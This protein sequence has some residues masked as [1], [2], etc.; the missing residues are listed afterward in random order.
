MS[1][2]IVRWNPFRE[3]AAMREAMDRI[4]EETWRPFFEEVSQGAF[5]LAVDVHE[6]NNAYTVV[7]SLPGVA[8][9]NINVRL[10][11]DVLMID[12]EIP[13]RVVEK[14]GT[15][16]LLR[17]RQY[18][19]FSRRIRLPQPVDSSKVEAQ[20]ENGVLTLTLPKA[21]EAQPKVIP[22]KVGKS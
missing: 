7:T 9:E 1:D 5:R 6:D 22:V 11:G 21:A 18:G 15:Q 19:R 16:T 12:G 2:N 3:M 14:E 4:F 17:E 8:P 13:E 20:Y 10:E